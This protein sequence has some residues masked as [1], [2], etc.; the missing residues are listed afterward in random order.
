MQFKAT[1][2]PQET[3]RGI[4][5][6][7]PLTPELWIKKK[8]NVTYEKVGRVIPLQASSNYTP[9]LPKLTPCRPQRGSVKII[10]LPAPT[11]ATEVTDIN[12]E[13]KMELVCLLCQYIIIRLLRLFQ[14][15]YFFKFSPIEWASVMLFF[16]Y[17]SAQFSSAESGHASEKC[18]ECVAARCGSAP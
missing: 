14:L 6:N 7:Y 2:T 12:W 9:T 15:R 5:L 8:L 17:I 1:K 3:L 4:T 10:F 16:K 13:R 11:R 18:A